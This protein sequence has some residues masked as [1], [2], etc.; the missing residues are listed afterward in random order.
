MTI[1]ESLMEFYTSC[2]RAIGVGELWMKIAPYPE[3]GPTYMWLS[4]TFKE[5]HWH[6]TIDIRDI[7]MENPEFSQFGEMHGR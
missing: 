6:K 1:N 3:N 5:W 7:L 4:W 2:E